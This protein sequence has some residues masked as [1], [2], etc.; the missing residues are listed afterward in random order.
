MTSL[1]P[2]LAGES[3]DAEIIRA[4]ER[5]RVRALVAGDVARAGP[6][7]AED[8]QLINPLGGVLSK[9]E[10][11]SGIGSRQIDYLFWE[12]NR[13]RPAST[14]TSRLFDTG[15]SLRSLCR[16]ATSRARGIGIPISM[17]GTRRSGR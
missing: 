1:E 2:G 4:T 8:F 6:L 5:E 11:L 12:P 9:E 7:H 17:N 15:R 10:Y 16:A 14:E 3:R 13:S